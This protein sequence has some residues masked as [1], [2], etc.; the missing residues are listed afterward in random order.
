MY[1]KQAKP[2]PFTVQSLSSMHA[3][4]GASL[5]DVRGWW[6]K[7]LSSSC[8]FPEAVATKRIRGAKLTVGDMVL[9]LSVLGHDVAGK[10]GGGRGANHH[11]LFQ[12]HGGQGEEEGGGG[13]ALQRQLR[14]A[15]KRSHVTEL[16]AAWKTRTGSKRKHCFGTRMTTGGGDPLLAADRLQLAGAPPEAV[17]AAGRG[18]TWRSIRRR[19]GP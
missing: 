10:G 9:M 16:S 6:F 1:W 14:H 3:L 12:G 19:A 7:P 11:Q 4:N 5:A 2:V 8:T 18:S 13:G 17:A 15:L